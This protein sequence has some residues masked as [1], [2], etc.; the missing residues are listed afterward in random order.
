MNAGVKRIFRI[1]RKVTFFLLKSLLIFLLVLTLFLA[2]N[3][4]KIDRTPY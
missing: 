1:I 4:I 3:I 2:L